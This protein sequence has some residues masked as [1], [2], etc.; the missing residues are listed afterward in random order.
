[1]FSNENTNTTRTITAEELGIWRVQELK[2]FCKEH[3]IKGYSKLRKAELIALITE[4][5]KGHDTAKTAPKTQ[6]SITPAPLAEKF[7]NTGMREYL[8]R[9]K[10]AEEKE[11][12]RCWQAVLRTLN[13]SGKTAEL[14]GE[15]E[16][17]KRNI[18]LCEQRIAQFETHTVKTDFSEVV[19][20]T[21]S[22]IGNFR[23]TIITKNR[24]AA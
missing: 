13:E 8:K 15:I 23:R 6:L 19:S 3:K 5:L 18:A 7:K 10:L 16:A 9:R 20:H 4:F 12:L 22:Y 2:N 21:A 11:F 24:K 1:M 17:A 14:E